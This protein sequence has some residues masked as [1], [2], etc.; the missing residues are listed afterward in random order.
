MTQEQKQQ[1]FE[2]FKAFQPAYM[3]ADDKA[4]NYLTRGFSTTQGAFFNNS[5]RV[6]GIT[7][8]ALDSFASVN[9]ERIPRRKDPIT[10]ERAHI[11]Q[12]SEWLSE[13]FES[14]WNNADEWWQF[15]WERDTCVLAT[16]NEN[17]ASDQLG[18]TLDIAYEIPQGMG[19]FQSNFIGCKYRKGMER[20]LIESF[21]KEQ[22][23]NNYLKI[24]A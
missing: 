15:I 6:V 19:Y 7:Q 9:F 12:R 21:A 24:N 3:A 8:A 17:H 14:E 5:W 23:V 18:G 22:I 16:K 4:R 10:V 11:H 2:I 1:Y 13:M 20:V